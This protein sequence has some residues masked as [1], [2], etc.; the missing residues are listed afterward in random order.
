MNKFIKKAIAVVIVLVS[1]F[2]TG[3]SQE[4]THKVKKTSTIPQKVHNVFSRHKEYSGY[5]S[6]RE[7]HGIK[8]KHKVNYRTGA[9][10]NKKSKA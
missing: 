4:S 5:K 9:V 7:R 8:R 10:R 1:L 6:K 3:Y 2:V